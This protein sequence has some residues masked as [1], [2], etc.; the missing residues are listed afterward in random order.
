MTISKLK[1][2]LF[3]Q[4]LVYISARSHIAHLSYPM[5]YNAA[6]PAI[7]TLF[8]AGTVFAISLPQDFSSQL[9]CIP[10]GQPCGPGSNCCALPGTITNASGTFE[11]DTPG[12]VF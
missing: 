11:V 8:A 1:Y 4:T 2:C 10:P 5:H 3:W 6:L 7:F 12:I 9:E